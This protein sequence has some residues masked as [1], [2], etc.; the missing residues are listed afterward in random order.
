MVATAGPKVAILCESIEVAREANELWRADLQLRECQ[1][2][3]AEKQAARD[4]CLI[5]A[6]QALTA[7]LSR[8]DLVVGSAQ[9]R[10]GGGMGKGGSAGKGKGGAE[11]EL[12][13]EGRGGED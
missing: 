5:G 9:G 4:E 13:T 7:A 10:V 6:V 2:A 1:L 11:P 12:S 8:T 3:M